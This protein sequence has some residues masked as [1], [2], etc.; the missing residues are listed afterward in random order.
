MFLD[1]NETAFSKMFHRQEVKLGHRARLSPFRA[2]ASARIAR[3][4]VNP[5]ASRLLCRRLPSFRRRPDAGGSV[6]LSYPRA[7]LVSGGVG[8]RGRVEERYHHVM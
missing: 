8:G 4:F 1:V 7:L 3:S 6:L 5:R 2:A